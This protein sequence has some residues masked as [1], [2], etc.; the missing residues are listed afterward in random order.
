M[1]ILKNKNS[2]LVQILAINSGKLR[3]IRF[4]SIL[5]FGI[6]NGCQQL[7]ERPKIG[8]TDTFRGHLSEWVAIFFCVLD[9]KIGNQFCIIVADK[10]LEPNFG[11][12]VELLL[13]IVILF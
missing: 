1:V 3:E 7:N 6:I 10:G 12:N 4:S 5:D 2:R 11:V 9:N 8:V 13:R